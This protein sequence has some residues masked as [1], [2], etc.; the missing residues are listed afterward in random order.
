MKA[1]C[2]ICPHACNLE[3]GQIGICRA[4]SNQ[5][6]AVRSDNYG[7]VTAIALD[8][9]EKKPLY[10]FHPGSKILSVGSYGCNMHCSFCQNY[11]I[12]MSNADHVDTVY[13]SA[14]DLVEKAAELQSGDNIGIAFTYNEP[15]IGYEYVRDCAT[16]AKDRGLQTVV[17]TNGYVNEAPL[18]DLLPVIDALNIDLKS[19]DAQFYE[20]CGGSL[21]DVKRSIVI[22]SESAHVEVSTL[23]IPNENDSEREMRAL[24]SWLADV[25]SE[26]P[27]HVSRFFPSYKMADRASTDVA[28]VYHLADIAREYLKYVYTGNC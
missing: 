12:S 13:F 24:A 23:I 22:A 4:R 3:E 7:L 25:N 19:F 2:D 28:S 11:R 5:G 18:R 8:P 26:T 6:G 17:V 20:R 15:L 21:E 27:L 16:V 10:H 9:I 14:D 1:I